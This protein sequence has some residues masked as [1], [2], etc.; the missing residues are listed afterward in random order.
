V[1]TVT[2][3]KSPSIGLRIDKLVDKYFRVTGT[4]GKAILS[5]PF[6]LYAG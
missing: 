5:D 3:T 4:N 2:I 6:F 1:P